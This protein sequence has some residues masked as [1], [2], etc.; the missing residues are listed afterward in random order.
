MSWN[1]NDYPASM[2]NLDGVVR[3]KAID[4]GNALLDSNY[5]EDRA[6]PI[7]ISQAKEW[8]KDASEKEVNSYKYQEN[9][10]KSDEH[11]DESNTDLLDNDV[12]VFFKEDE[13]KVQT[14]GAKR[15]DSTFS[16]KQDAIDRAKEIAQNK[17]SK[18][19]RYTKEGKKQD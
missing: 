8:Y 9:P 14:Q 3:K 11:D 6:I 5:P 13:W 10:K 7:A 4:I 1:T 18:V 15:P 2:K 17:N 19:V 16:H 12:K